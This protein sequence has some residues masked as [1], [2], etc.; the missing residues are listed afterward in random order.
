MKVSDFAQNQL[1]KM[2]WKEGQGLGKESTGIKTNIKVQVKNNDNGLGHTN[3]ENFND[4]WWNDNVSN[5]LQRLSKDK[6]KKRKKKSGVSTSPEDEIFHATGGIQIGM[7]R[8]V[9]RVSS[10]TITT[11]D[12]EEGGK[13]E[14]NG[15]DDAKI[16]LNEQSKD[17]ADKQKKKKDKKNKKK[18]RRKDDTVSD[19]D[20]SK[21]KK[22]RKEKSK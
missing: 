1:K 18:K 3:I 21:K 16:I 5:T 4:T 13:F 10:S 15:L 17:N 14:W 8:I 2:G 11:N 9:R 19:E 6:K 7:R 12:K 22:R 20:G